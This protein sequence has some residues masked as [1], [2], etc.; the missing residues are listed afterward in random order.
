MFTLDIVVPTHNRSRLLRRTLDSLLA[1]RIPRGVEV[2]LFVIGNACVDDSAEVVAAARAQAPFDVQWIVEPRPGKSFALNTGISRGEGE[3][4]AFFDDDIAVDSGWLEEF[5]RSVVEPGLD[6]C[7]GR[8]EAEFEEK[9]PAWLPA[10]SAS[11]ILVIHRDTPSERIFGGARF[12]GGNC[13]IRR[14]VLAATG[15][16]DTENARTAGKKGL[17]TEDSDMA[18]RMVRAGFEGWYL[19]ALRA[20]HWIPRERMHKKYFRKHAFWMAY[21]WGALELKHAP[22]SSSIPQW[23]GVPRWRYRELLLAFLHWLAAWLRLAPESSRMETELRI[24]SVSGAILAGIDAHTGRA[25]S[26]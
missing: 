23:F 24:R 25:H 3:W 19:P 14:R 2:H 21:S 20:R 1:L 16:F 10:E 8:Y 4:V 11:R 26:R 17:G 22:E 7:A 18:F 5:G 6:F 15:P 13:A 9:P 12:A